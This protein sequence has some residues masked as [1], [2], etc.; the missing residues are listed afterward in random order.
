MTDPATKNGLA[1]MIMALSMFLLSVGDVTVRYIGK[2]VPAGQII[3]IRGVILIAML[4]PLM[5]IMRDPIK[6][7]Y[8]TNPWALIRGM[9]EMVSTYCFFISI[10]L[11]PIAT[12][13]TIVFI[14]PVLLT[15]ISIPLFGEKVGAFRLGAVALGFL[16]VVVIAAPSGEAFDMAMIYPLI[17][18]IGLVVRDL[19]TRRIDDDI[20]SVS[21]ILTTAM[22]TSFGGFLS[23][24]WGWVQIT[25]DLYPVFVI[26]A[27]LVACSFIAYVMAIRLGELSVIAPT[28]YMVILWA[29]IWGAI[30]WDE[31][32]EAR[33]WLGGG[34]IITA[35]LVILWREHVKQIS[36]EPS[37][38][39][40]E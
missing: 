23:I 28:Q 1:L 14:F 21:I 9:A 2:S 4:L 34:M 19:V 26:A 30:F 22:V 13:T 36:R 16:G 20:S 5:G 37:A 24:P 17:T 31:I 3:A 40:L 11:I 15:L 35:G 32:P 39:P 33:A 7:R 10:Q 25:S 12:S 18:A 8:V 38:L 6:L 27:A 29:T